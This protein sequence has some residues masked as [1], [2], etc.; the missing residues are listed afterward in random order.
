M[1]I[2]T[3]SHLDYPDFAADFSEVM[4]RAEAAAVTRLIS[5]GTRIDSSQA[6]LGLAKKH[7]NVWSTAGV[8]PS[9]ADEV[10]DDF[11]DQLRRLATD[12]RVAAIGEIGLD[13]Y[14]LPEPERVPEYKRK[15][16]EVFRL[17]LDLAV[18]LGLNVVIHQRES[19][20]DCWAILSEYQGRVRGV[21]H[22]FGGSIEQAHQVIDAGHLVSFTGIVSFKN[23]KLLHETVAKVPASAFMVETDC[24]YLAPVP[25]RGQRCEP[26][27]TRLVAERVAELRGTPWETIA[28]ETTAVAERFFRLNR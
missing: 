28:R 8:H 10:P 4:A 11:I 27:Y 20:D 9:E 5:I 22:C 23:A 18:E 16:A 2:D 17:Q 3:H 13:Y 15:Q 6:A 21:Y 12:S 25:H 19:W 26:A 14:R 1:L 24:P 7:A